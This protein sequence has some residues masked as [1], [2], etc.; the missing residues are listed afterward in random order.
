ILGIN[1]GGL[2]FLTEIPFE[3]FGREF[4]KILNGEYR[5]EKRL[6]LKGEIDKDLQPLYALNEFV[7][8]KGKSVRVIQIQTQVDGRLLNSYVSDGL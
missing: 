8:D 6:M 5:I 7:I 4:N 3:N 1:L 2:G